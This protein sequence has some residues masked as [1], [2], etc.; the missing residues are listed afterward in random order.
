MEIRP[1]NMKPEERFSRTVVGILMITA[2]FVSWGKWLSLVLGILFLVSA[3]LGYCFT[4]ELYKIF[5]K[6]NSKI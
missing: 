5:N 2:A 1:N 3:W 6:S 4:C